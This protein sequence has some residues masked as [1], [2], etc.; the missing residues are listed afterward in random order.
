MTPMMQAGLNGG[1]RNGAAAL[2]DNGRVVAV[3]AEERVTRVRGGGVPGGLPDEALDLLLQRRGQTRRDL[4]RYVVVDGGA[5]PTG[6]PAEALDHHRAHA[7]VAYLSSPFAAAAIV[8]CDHDEPGVSVWSGDGGVITRVDWPR[9]DLG[10]AAAYFRVA[11]ALGFHT[12]AAG[13]RL[14]ALARLQPGARDAAVDALFGWR[15]GALIV[16]PALEQCLAQMAGSAESADILPRAR[17]ASAAQAR[18]GEL[19]VA[20]LADVQQRLGAERLCVGGS[21]FYQ[22]YLNTLMRR[23]GLFADVFVPVDPGDSGLAVG[24]VLHGMGGA[25]APISPFLGPAYSA[26]EVKAVLD[27]CKLNYSWESEEGAVAAAVHALRE[28]HLVGWFDGGME[29]GPRALGAR[30]ILASPLQPYVLENLNRFLKQREPWRG[31]ALSG[32]AAAV[33]EH[34]DGPARAPFMECDFTPRDPERFRHV[35]PTAGAAVRVQTVD[36]DGLPRFSRLLEAAGADNG[37]PFLVNTSFNGFHEPIVCSPRDAVRVFYGSG[38][39]LLVL[40]QFI[41]RK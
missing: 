13:Q 17:V 2:G 19:V 39:D 28:G 11:A 15:D 23:S 8:V 41:L 37:L 14:E 40:N 10:F 38:L 27:N 34:F 3:C 7:S 12:G 24:A 5:L 32:T 33:A 26:E 29:W 20:L 25:P 22:S 4:S 35:L 1:V 9:A 30:C 36:S 21:L 6:A 16:D 31:Y 18:L